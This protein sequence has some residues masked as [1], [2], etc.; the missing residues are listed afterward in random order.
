M[1]NRMRARSLYVRICEFYDS[2]DC[3]MAMADNISTRGY[4][5]R[6]ELVRLWATLKDAP[7]LPEWMTRDIPT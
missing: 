2:Y 4:S 1:T 5:M 7:P 3:G 6:K